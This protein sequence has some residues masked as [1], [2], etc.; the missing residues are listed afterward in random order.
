MEIEL[1]HTSTRKATVI[2]LGELSLCFS[3]QTLI[4]CSYDGLTYRV[5]NIWGPTSGRHFN[6]L[7]LKGA[8]VM[9]TKELNKFVEQAIYEMGGRALEREIAKSIL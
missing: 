7:G 3:Y 4:G 6:Q 5:P 8:Q 1:T 9:Q 2:T